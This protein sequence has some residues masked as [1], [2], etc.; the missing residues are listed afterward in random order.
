MTVSSTASRVV[1]NG[2]GTTTAW[3]F[4]FK[5]TDSSAIVAIYTDT[6]GNQT[7]LSYGSQFT[8]AGFGLD[9][10]GTVT[11]PLSG[12]PIAVG[13]TLTIYRNVTPTQPTSISNQGAMWPSVIEAAFDR[14]TYI[15]QGFVDGLNRTLKI[16]NTDGSSLNPL[17]VAA[18]RAGT[19]LAFDVNGQPVA[20]S[21]LGRYRGVWA[22]AQAYNLGDV[23]LDG[24]N[25]A[26]TSNIYVATAANTSGTWSTDLPLYWKLLVSV[27]SLQPVSTSTT[28]LTIGTG[29]T[30]LTVGKGL[31][32][33]VGQYLVIA[34]TSAPTNYMFGQVTAYNS[35]TGSLTVNVTQTGGS[36][37][38]AAWT[39]SLSGVPATG[40]LLASNNLSDVANAGTSRNNLGA[41]GKIVRQVFTSSGTYTP[42]AN[43]LY[44]DIECLGGGAAGGSTA[45]AGASIGCGGGGGGAGSYSRKRVTATDIGASKPVTIGAGGTPGAAGNN[46]GGNGGDTSV[47]SL[48]I[49]KGATGGSG[50]N[51]S[52]TANG[53]LGGVPGTGDVPGAGA[54][55]KACVAMGGNNNSAGGYGADSPY[56]G[57]GR[58]APAG[59]AAAGEAATGYG[60]GGSG[61]VSYNAGGTAVGGAGAPGL[62]IVTEYCSS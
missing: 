41:V 53:G 48:C 31:P 39:I 25:G 32:F 29:S 33:A 4:A 23:V 34:Q 58:T 36:G 16:S 59:A 40:A 3:P 8:A 45:T 42:T 46:P 47:G 51:G 19:F 38:V 57:G 7:T 43:M 62:V 6:N 12:S 56:G 2:D 27:A 15:V 17:P 9:A 24:S 30:T 37:T 13:T 18:T 52:S 49:A 21:T 35:A 44:A 26:S 50:C 11:Y 20:A 22:T 61:A 5:I 54:N 60:A 1:Y 28:S 10:G 14:L 55:G